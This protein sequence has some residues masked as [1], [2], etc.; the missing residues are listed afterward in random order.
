MVRRDRQPQGPHLPAHVRARRSAGRPAA[1]HAC[2]RVLHRQR[3]NR[4][5]LRGRREGLPLHDRDARRH[6]RRAQEDHARLRRRS[7]LHTRRR[8][9]RRSVARSASRRFAARRR[10]GYWVPGQFDNA[11]NVE[12]HYRTTGPEIWEQ[13][14]GIVG[15]FVASQGSGG[16]LTGVGR[17]LREQD[18]R[19]RLYAV[20]PEECALLAR[21]EWGPHGIEGIGDGFIPENLDVAIISGVITTTTDE[22][23][24]MAR[25]L[26]R[27]G[28]DL[29][30]H[31]HRVQ[32]RRRAQAGAASPGPA[33]DRDDGQRHGAALLHDGAVRRGQ[34]S[35]R[36]GARA[37]DGSA[38]AAASSISISRRGRSS[39]EPGR[40]RLHRR[41]PAGTEAKAKSAAEKLTS[42]EDAVGRVKD[43]DHVGVGGCLFS[44]P[45]M[46]LMR[47]ILR[48]RPP[49]AH[50]R[51]QPHLHRGRAV[52]GG[53]R[54]QPR[55]DRAGCRSGC[56]GACRRSCA[57]TSRRARSR[58]KNGAISRRAPVP[59]RRDGRAV[60]AR[61]HDARLGPRRGRR[62]QDGGRIPTPARR[63]RPCRRSS[64]TWRC[65][66]CT[67]RIGS[68]TARSTA[69]RTWT[70]TSRGPRRRSW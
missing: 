32:R 62:P 59:R 16:T 37:S 35:R 22:S 70:P 14:G 18:T 27:R 11:D 33:V 43:G 63:S 42:L 24:I 39:P 31:L 69:T 2:A 52:H 20:E 49:R 8:E 12:A 3:R 21:R 54:R 26:A 45:P 19:V 55:H 29:L 66:T 1:G 17:F 67:A 41:A 15:A 38:D 40:I 47:E 9:R 46:A 10:T 23:L 58:W 44:R 53:G 4:L 6:E 34:E 68:A 36:A 25:R 57:T 50:A 51:A 64:R 5:R 65:C 61:A 13:A 7:R 60:P 56:R 28:G 48:Q 30:R